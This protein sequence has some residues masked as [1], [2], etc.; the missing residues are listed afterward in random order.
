MAISVK[1]EIGKL[2]K[3]MLHRPGKELEHLVPGELERRQSNSFHRTYL[4]TPTVRLRQFLPWIFPASGP[5]CIWIQVHEY[6]PLEGGASG[7]TV[8]KMSR[9]N[10][11]KH[12]TI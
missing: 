3:V 10:C 5:I 4:R 11:C 6:A 1:S 9:M 12:I 7:F 2:R 8:K